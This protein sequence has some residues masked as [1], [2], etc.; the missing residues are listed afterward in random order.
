MWFVALEPDV[1]GTCAEGLDV[2]DIEE[3]GARGRA[4]SRWCMVSSPVPRVAKCAVICAN[5][6][7]SS[8]AL[9]RIRWIVLSVVISNNSA[10]LSDLLF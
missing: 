3:D 2:E 8:V 9:V 6:K 4:R 5:G 1:E 7:S 10:G